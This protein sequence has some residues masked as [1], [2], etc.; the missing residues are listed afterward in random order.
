MSNPDDYLKELQDFDSAQGKARLRSLVLS[1]HSTLQRLPALKQE[2]DVMLQSTEALDYEELLQRVEP[3]LQ[4][5]SDWLL[6]VDLLPD[7]VANEKSIQDFI[8]KF[9]KI[10]RLSTISQLIQQF[11]QELQKIP[12]GERLGKFIINEGIITDTET[13]LTWLRFAI[14]QAWQNN[15]V[16]DNANTFT[17]QQ[18]LDITTEFNRRGGYA[19]FTDWRLPTINELKTFFG[20]IRGQ[21]FI[22]IDQIFPNNDNNIRFWSSSPNADNSNNAWVFFYLFDMHDDK[23]SKYLVRLVRG[24]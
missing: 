13:D 19:G 11:E 12:K 6:K 23:S 15:T 10:M 20:K 8:A 7:E 18:A 2:L 14:G 21:L 3:V 16:V 9:C 4:Q 24:G 22:D 1:F 5:G 17:W